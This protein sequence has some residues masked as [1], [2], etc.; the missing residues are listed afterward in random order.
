MGSP[1]SLP[2]IEINLNGSQATQAPS[3]LVTNQNP[4]IDITSR[5]Y[6]P[7]YIRVKKGEP[8]NLTLKSKDA[9]SCASAFTIPSLGIVKTLAPND[10]QTIAFTPT[11]AGKITFTCSMGMYSGVIEV[12]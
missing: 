11:Q 5:G 9:L 8:V 12:L 6:S 3:S 7:N 1:I 2:S 10:I 4:E